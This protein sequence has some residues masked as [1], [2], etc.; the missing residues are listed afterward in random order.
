MSPTSR[1]L[2]LA[3]AWLLLAVVA[4]AFPALLAG[5]QLLGGIMGLVALIDGVMAWFQSPL[6]I[7]R[8]LPGRFAAGEPGEVGLIVRNPS[9]RSARIEMFDGVPQGSVA[10]VMPW[11]GEVPP[12]REIRVFHPVII[13]QRG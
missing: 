12:N 2:L 7:R 9:P 13:H 5:W 3:L 4:L 6:E 11:K 1:L 8:R 10:E